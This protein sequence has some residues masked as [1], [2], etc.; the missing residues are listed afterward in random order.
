M[1]A[2]LKRA[3]Y[4]ACFTGVVAVFAIYAANKLTGWPT[5]PLVLWIILA[6]AA[7][8]AIV[9]APALKWL[10][11]RIERRVHRHYERWRASPE[12]QAELARRHAI[13]SMPLA[14]ARR[15][16]EDILAQ[17]PTR[18]AASRPPDHIASLPC[19]AGELFSRFELIRLDEFDDVL[20]AAAV[21]PIRIEGRDLI[22]IGLSE[23]GSIAID[24][25][26]PPSVIYVYGAL[27]RSDEPRCPSVYHLLLEVGPLGGFPFKKCRCGYSREGLD[28][29]DPCPE[30]GLQTVDL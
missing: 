12:G 6:A 27:P 23:F 11:R 22:Q 10:E 17:T 29:N 4:A 20:S 2:R 19:A 21:R 26:P 30:C 18:A 13:L 3:L 14:E 28:V 1:A 25:G 8:G 5:Y 15:A 9:S 7:L 24:P 16:A